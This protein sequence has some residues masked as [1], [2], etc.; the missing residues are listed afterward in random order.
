MGGAVKEEGDD[1]PQ[2]SEIRQGVGLPQQWAWGETGWGA[3][4]WRAREGPETWP[5][6]S[7]IPSCPT[8]FLY[9]IQHKPQ[10]FA[11]SGWARDPRLT[12]TLC[13]TSVVPSVK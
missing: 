5:P 6:M 2:E 11:D 4:G 13:T 8:S 10:P 9:S 3:V 12:Q 1:P 7:P